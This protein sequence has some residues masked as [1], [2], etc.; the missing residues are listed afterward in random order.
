MGT[1]TKP[2]VIGTWDSNQVNYAQPAST[3]Q[4]SGYAVNGVI[5][6][7]HINYC[8]NAAYQWENWLSSAEFGYLDLAQTWTASQTFSAPLVVSNATPAGSDITG[9]LTVTGGVGVQ[10]DVH[11]GGTIVANQWNFT[12]GAPQPANSNNWGFLQ[13]STTSTVDQISGGDWRWIPQNA[14]AYSAPVATLTTAGVLTVSSISASSIDLT[15]A[16]GTAITVTSTDQASISTPGGITAATGTFSGS[17]SLTGNG[18]T[19][20]VLS[21]ASNAVQVTGGVYAS[22][23]SFPQVGGTGITVTSDSLSVYEEGTFTVTP[24]GITDSNSNTFQYIRIGRHVTILTDGVLHSATGGQAIKYPLPQNLVP[25][26]DQYLQANAYTGGTS[27]EFTGIQV[28][29][30]G[31]TF[32]YMSTTGFSS[33]DFPAGTQNGLYNAIISY[34]L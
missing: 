34:L 25:A 8:W 27:Y 11:V 13:N 29:A 32:G 19:L 31:I 2:S 23:I 17:V 26:T 16:T 5:A 28:A 3:Y 18:F 15:A 4:T 10:G 33:A 1:G 22:S 14:S 6:S 21:N 9:A 30:A 20:A 7:Q 24:T 12:G